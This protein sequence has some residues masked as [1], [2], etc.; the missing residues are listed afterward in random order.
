AI[1]TATA[2]GSRSIAS[3]PRAP[4]IRPSSLAARGTSPSHKRTP[5]GLGPDAALSEALHGEL[6]DQPE[7]AGTAFGIDG[8]VDIARPATIARHRRTPRI[9]SDAAAPP[10]V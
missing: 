6:L 9:T 10:S 7:P 3:T 8:A 4:E 2:S 1:P 5:R